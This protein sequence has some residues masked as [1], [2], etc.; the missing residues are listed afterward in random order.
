MSASDDFQTTIAQLV[1]ENANLRAELADLRDGIVAFDI[2]IYDGDEAARRAAIEK[3]V[4]RIVAKAAEV[5]CREPVKHPP[6]PVVPR[7]VTP[8][9][10]YRPGMTYEEREQQLAS[11]GL[12]HTSSPSYWS[13][14]QAEW[15]ARTLDIDIDGGSA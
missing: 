10:E 1:G 6:S 4:T 12:T 14:H 9:L 7:P 8:G 11:F 13:S 3:I 2:D 15:D 5:G